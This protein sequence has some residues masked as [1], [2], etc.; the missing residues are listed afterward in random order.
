MDAQI[1]ALDQPLVRIA[2][3]FFPLQNQIDITPQEK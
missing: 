3:Y 2:K 1:R